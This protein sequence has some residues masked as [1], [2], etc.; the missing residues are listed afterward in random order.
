MKILHTS[1]WHLGKRLESFSRIEEQREVMDE[2]CDIALQQNVDVVLVAGDLFDTI[3]PPTEAVE[4]L[5]HTLKRLTNNGQCAVVAIAGNHDSPDRIEAPDPLARECGIVFAGYPNSQIT[6]FC[7]DSGI[8]VL[9]SD[10]GFVE[11]QLPRCNA[12]LRLFL[13]PYA[14]E[15]R[16]R[17][18][19]GQE[20]NEQELRNVLTDHWVKGALQYADGEGVNVLMTH[21]FMIKEG[22]TPPEEPEDEKSILYVGGAQTVFSESI[23]PSIQYTALG[24]LHRRQVIDQT[25]GPVVYSGSPLAYSFSEANQDKYVILADVEPG[26]K[27]VVTSVELKKCR[28]LLRKRFEEVQTA[29]NWLIENPDVYVELT[30]VSDNFLSAAE[31]RQ[32]NDAHARIVAIIPE[33]RNLDLQ[34]YQVPQIDVSRSMEELFVDFFQHSKQQQPNERIMNLFKEL[35]AEDNA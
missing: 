9:R 1:D 20:N 2:I 7:L 30:I 3:N 33:V 19:L 23:P 31:R 4:L 16:L 35:L 15:V 10:S 27:A 25:N 13:T 21:L 24:H 34:T 26:Q 8:K 18:C 28:R 32:L 17:M 29:V 14:N 6:P 12:P 5:Y 11:L 22:T